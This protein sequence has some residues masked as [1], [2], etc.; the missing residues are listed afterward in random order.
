MRIYSRSCKNNA[1]ASLLVLGLYA[2]PAL[3]AAPYIF[4]APPMASA[5]EAQRV[6]APIVH[7]LSQVT[8]KKFVFLSPLNWVR[9]EQWTRINKGDVYFDGAQFAA[10]RVRNQGA[11][12]GP[13]V[14]NGKS[15]VMFSRR[16]SGI[17]SIETTYG[18]RFCNT[19]A[20]ALS[21]LWADGYY[22]DPARLPAYVLMNSQRQIIRAVEEKTCA[23][24]VATRTA[25]EKMDP[26][27]HLQAFLVSST[28]PGPAFTFS[29][30]LPG[31]MVARLRKALLS[32]AG[33]AATQA[34]RSD[35]FSA[36]L[37]PARLS[38]YAPMA[39]G[40]TGYWSTMYF[41]ATH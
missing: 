20:P 37:V 11:V 17:T 34:L 21:G 41:G 23:Y 36:H 5:A 40:L 8:G 32:P 15:L 39:Q 12:L 2:V 30:R 9:Y 22:T 4:T 3:S 14:A 31:T 1:L 29:R 28:F 24:G 13:R 10:W 7:F 27:H 16:G 33:Q 6:Y 25:I 19:P 38:Q 18:K 35:T 26:H